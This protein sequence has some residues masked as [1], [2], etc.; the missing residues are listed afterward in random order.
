MVTIQDY[1][2]VEVKIS[3][4]R[5]YTGRQ[6]ASPQ[7]GPRNEFYCVDSLA[8]M[9]KIYVYLHVVKFIRPFPMASTFVGLISGPCLIPVLQKDL[10]KCI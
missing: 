9:Q 6:S 3:S 8:N 7:E 4:Q 1:G 10:H 2:S 5:T